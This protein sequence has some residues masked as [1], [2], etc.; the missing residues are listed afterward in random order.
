MYQLTY[1]K[2]ILFYA[3]VF[4]FDRES[5]RSELIFLAQ[6]RYI[7]D[8]HSKILKQYSTRFNIYFTVFVVLT[9]H[10]TEEEIFRYVDVLTRHQESCYELFYQS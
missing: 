3:L 9:E 2:Y 6:K 7:T 8:K 5:E 4:Y 10:M 1:L